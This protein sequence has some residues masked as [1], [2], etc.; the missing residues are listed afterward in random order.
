[1]NLTTKEFAAI[2]DQLSAEQT[3]VKKFTMYAQMT[4]DP[5]LKTQ[6]EAHSAKHQNHF[7]RLL[8]QL[9]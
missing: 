8:S 1:M 6:F 4:K 3:L 5:Q 2:E 7:N 9:N